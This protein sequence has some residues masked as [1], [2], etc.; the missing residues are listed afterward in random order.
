MTQTATP[1]LDSFDRAIL[2]IVQADKQLSYGE[3]G[4]KVGLSASAVRRRLGDL[5][6]RGVIARDVSIL[7][8]DSFG[9]TLIVTVSFAVESLEIYAD[10]ERTVQALPQVRQCYHVAGSSDYVLIVQ[11]PTLQFYEA[12]S[13]RHFMSNDAIRRYDTI[14]AWSCKKFETAIDLEA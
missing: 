11:V 7:D 5:R 6:G 13:M 3:I 4:D 1:S 8:A 2:G 12:W 9:P 10:F 14:V